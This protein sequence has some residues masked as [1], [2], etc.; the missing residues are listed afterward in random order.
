MPAQ[1]NAPGSTPGP[2]GP[3]STCSPW[4]TTGDVC[5]PCDDYALDVTLLE[6]SIQMASDVLYNLTGRRWPGECI[7]VVRPQARWRA[8]AAPAWWPGDS[9][10]KWGW[11]SC[12]RGRETGCSSVS[13]VRLPG[14]GLVD[15]ATIYVKIDGSAFA[16]WRLDDDR[17]LVRTDG[18]GWPCCQRLEL[19]DAEPD[20]WSITYT[21]DGAPPVGG[22]IAAASLGCQLALACQP[23]AVDAG[24]CRLPKRITS[25]TRQGVTI[26][27]LDPLTLF[28]DGQTGLAE[29]DLWVASVIAGDQR[30]RA[31]VLIPGRPRAVRRPAS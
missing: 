10:S 9:S 3:G 4:A 18:E 22:R 6:D 12:S 30:R 2:P 19:D 13:E 29:V 24:A 23:E 7:D 5:S 15:P 25:I 31:N 11:C 8:S 20:T 26:A 21:R 16:N 17:W 28:A 14:E 27:V 1:L